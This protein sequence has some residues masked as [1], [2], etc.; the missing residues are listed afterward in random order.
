MDGPPSNA[1]LRNLGNKRVKVPPVIGGQA[2]TSSKRAAGSG[3][4]HHRVSQM[5]A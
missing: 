1:P 2:S 4:F 3:D 5:H